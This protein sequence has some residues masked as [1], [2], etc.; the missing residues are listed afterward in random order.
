MNII[1]EGALTITGFE[2]AN[3]PVSPERMRLR[4]LVVLKDWFMLSV[5]A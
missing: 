5:K 3:L 1:T 2:E 4:E